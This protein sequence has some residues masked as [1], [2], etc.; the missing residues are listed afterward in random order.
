MQHL[1]ERHKPLTGREVSQGLI[2]TYYWIAPLLHEH[3]INPNVLGHMRTLGSLF[4]Y[5]G[6]IYSLLVGDNTHGRKKHSFS[7]FVYGS[8]VRCMVCYGSIH[9]AVP[10]SVNLHFVQIHKIEI[11]KSSSTF[12]YLEFILHCMHVLMCTSIQLNCTLLVHRS[13]VLAKNPTRRQ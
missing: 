3:N 10:R 9:T 8:E 1:Y 12:L 2:F 4:R 5:I 6:N 13:R 11:E 7:I